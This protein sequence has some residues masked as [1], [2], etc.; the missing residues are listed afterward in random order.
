MIFS[1]TFL[2]LMGALR[3]STMG[4]TLTRAKAERHNWETS[5]QERENGP[6]ALKSLSNFIGVI[7][8]RRRRR[9]TRSARVSSV[10]STGCKC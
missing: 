2:P 9:I 10:S 1:E 3:W 8:G 5:S 7:F 4:S 6:F